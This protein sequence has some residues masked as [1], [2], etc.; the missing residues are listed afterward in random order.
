MSKKRGKVFSFYVDLELAFDRI[1]RQ[2]LNIMMIRKEIGVH[3]RKR[4]LEIYKETRN[5]IRIK[6][7]V[8]SWKR[9]LDRIAH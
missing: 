6:R 5:V 3:L 4:I 9:E 2:E 7:S 1:D 8:A